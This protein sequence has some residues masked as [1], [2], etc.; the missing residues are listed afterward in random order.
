MKK[1]SILS[2]LD[3]IL[4]SICMVI[5]IGVT[6]LGVFMRYVVKSPLMW[7]EEVSMFFFVWL[8]LLGSAS[9]TKTGGHVSIDVIVEKMSGN[10]RKI[11]D[12]IVAAVVIVTLA[13]IIKN[14]LALAL[15]ARMKV[16]PILRVPY[17]YIDIAIPIGLAWMLIYYVKQ[18]LLKMKA[19]EDNIALSKENE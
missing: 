10:A 9:A 18:T 15:Q 8:A 2:N 3:D 12:M 6:V 16:T 1:K 11:V 19:P 17:T 13:I 5:V 7:I 14:G 4:A